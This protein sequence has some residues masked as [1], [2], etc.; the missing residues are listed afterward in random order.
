MF[1]YIRRIKTIVMVLKCNYFAIDFYQ[2]RGIF[3]P[4]LSSISFASRT[5]CFSTHFLYPLL[6]VHML[7]PLHGPFFASPRSHYQIPY[8]QFSSPQSCF[9]QH[10]NNPLRLF[11]AFIHQVQG[12]WWY[13]LRNTAYELKILTGFSFSI[14]RQ[15]SEQ[16]F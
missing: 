3:I 2:L 10:R 5:S 6:S 7:F 12:R 4:F 15:K 1:K 13:G 9:A 8:I 11:S 14:P 16:N